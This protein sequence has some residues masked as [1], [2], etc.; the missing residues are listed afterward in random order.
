MGK[1]QLYTYL[2]TVR[3][4]DHLTVRCGSQVIGQAEKL[5]PIYF[6]LII[7]KNGKPTKQLQGFL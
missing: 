4:Q 1:K 7:G 3:Q 2:T 6:N 5:A